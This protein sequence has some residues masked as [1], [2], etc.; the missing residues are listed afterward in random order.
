[1]PDELTVVLPTGKAVPTLRATLGTRDAPL[2]A[3]ALLVPWAP[4]PLQV[5]DAP[6]EAPYDLTGGDAKRGEQVFHSE[7]SKCAV[8]HKVGEKGGNV[9][10]DLTRPR[11]ADL[12]SLY[13]AIAAPSDEIRPDY[14]AYTVATNDGQVVAGIVRAEGADSVRVL[15]TEG[16]ATIF[17]RSDIQLFKPSSTSIMPV[18]LAGALGEEKMGDLLAFLMAGQRQD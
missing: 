8:C 4:A 6:F 5:S 10:P 18:G 16:K 3:K 15:D 1:L 14:V 17:K 2:P 13:R 9:G 11:Q 7:E 12:L